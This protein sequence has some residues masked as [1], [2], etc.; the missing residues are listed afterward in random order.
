MFH[1]ANTA[2]GQ[3]GAQDKFCVLNVYRMLKTN[4][5]DHFMFNHLSPSDYEKPSNVKQKHDVTHF[6]RDVPHGMGSN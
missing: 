2:R 6:F 3:F 5:H 4:H 1:T